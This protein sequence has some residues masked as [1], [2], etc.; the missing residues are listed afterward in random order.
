[1]NNKFLFLILLK[2][3]LF[4]KIINLDWVDILV[5]VWSGFSFNIYNLILIDLMFNK[6]WGGGL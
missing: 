5:V 4:F 6:I 1:M 3:K 2:K